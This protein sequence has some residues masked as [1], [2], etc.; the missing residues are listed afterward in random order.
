MGCCVLEPVTLELTRKYLEYKLIET[1]TVDGNS[2]KEL[3]VLNVSRSCE[4]FYYVIYILAVKLPTK[5]III[6]VVKIQII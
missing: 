5:F 3:S 6:L 4:S 1:Y 2:D